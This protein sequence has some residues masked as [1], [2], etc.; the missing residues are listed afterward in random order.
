MTFHDEISIKHITETD[1]LTPPP[2]NTGGRDGADRGPPAHSNHTSPAPKLDPAIPN[3]DSLT[4]SGLIATIARNAA[5]DVGPCTAHRL[6][7]AMTGAIW[8]PEAVRATTDLARA[9]AHGQAIVLD[10]A[11]LDRMAGQMAF[12]PVSGLKTIRGDGAAARV[13]AALAILAFAYSQAGTDTRV[14]LEPGAQGLTVRP[15]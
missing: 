11:M 9:L 7:R 14:T 5:S 6:R 2:A 3:P 12:A 10:S 4:L 15:A 1:I 13:A 8:S